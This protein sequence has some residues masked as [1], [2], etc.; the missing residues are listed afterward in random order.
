MPN[1]DLD[2]LVNGPVNAAFGESNTGA[3][4]VTYTP[5]GGAPFDLDGVFDAAWREVE[6]RTGGR[7]SM[8]MPISTTKPAFGCRLSDFPEGVTPQQGDTFVRA[9]DPSRTY[10]V[11]DPRPDGVSGWVHLICN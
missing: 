6:M 4:L 7:H 9:S 11:S 10:T 3:G 1:L 5:A 8:S 2:A